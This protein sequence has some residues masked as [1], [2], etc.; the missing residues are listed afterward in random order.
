VSEDVECFNR[1]GPGCQ[2]KMRDSF[3]LPEAAKAA[4]G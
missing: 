4:V 1:R 2:Q 3:L